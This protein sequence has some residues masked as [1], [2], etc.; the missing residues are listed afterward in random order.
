[1]SGA[2]CG[3]KTRPNFPH[4]AAL[5]RATLR[6]QRLSGALAQLVAPLSADDAS[7]DPPYYASRSTAPPDGRASHSAWVMAVEVATI[8]AFWFFSASEI[9]AIR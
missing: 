4:V 8:C 2:I 5:M 7:A 3:A 1:M 9:S 6:P